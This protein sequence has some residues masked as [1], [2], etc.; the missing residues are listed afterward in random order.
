MKRQ[1]LLILLLLAMTGCAT[2][3]SLN[4]K[5]NTAVGPMN[6]VTYYTGFS[7]KP[8]LEQVVLFVRG[9]GRFPASHDFGM[10]AEATLLG[11]AVVYPQKSYVDDE[12]QYFIHD[13][14]DQRLHDLTVICDDLIRQGT[15]RILLLADSEG[16]MLA[17]ELARRYKDYVCGLVC[18]G[19][20]LATFE[21]DIRY[22]HA[23]G[24]GLFGQVHNPELQVW[25][26]RIAQDPD[27]R[28]ESFLGHSFH[29]WHSY[30][31]LDPIPELKSLTCPIFYLN[32]EYDGVDFERQEQRLTHLRTAG[33][34]IEQKVYPGVGHELKAV[35]KTLAR[36]ILEW[37]RRNQVF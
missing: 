37:A 29:F 24:L 18:M 6:P 34:R 9:T 12:T 11:F 15:K 1:S 19:G 14:H 17:P 4:L 20:S 27:N 32:G 13:G 7:G 31:N 26:E 36:D 30:L 28:Q 21:E 5:Q 10:G 2:T 23:K 22:C 35:G 25:L 8:S 16:T 3:V 33:V